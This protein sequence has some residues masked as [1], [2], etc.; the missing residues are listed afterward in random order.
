MFV[1]ACTRGKAP[2]E[3]LMDRNVYKSFEVE[4]RAESIWNHTGFLK[5]LLDPTLVNIAAKFEIS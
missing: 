1:D 5:T 4:E 2:M 3:R